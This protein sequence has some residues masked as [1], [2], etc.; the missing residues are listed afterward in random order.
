[1]R[2]FEPSLEGTIDS[3]GRRLQKRLVSS[4]RPFPSIAEKARTRDVEMFE[5]VIPDPV[6]VPT[7]DPD[8][9]LLL[10][11]DQWGSP[12]GVSVHWGGESDAARLRPPV[13]WLAPDE[14]A[15]V[16][17]IARNAL[18]SDPLA[19]TLS[20]LDVYSLI[21]RWLILATSGPFRTLSSWIV[22][23]AS[24][25][26][27]WHWIWFRLPADVESQLPDDEDLQLGGFVLRQLYRSELR[28]LFRRA[29]SPELPD[30]QQQEAIR[31]G[32]DWP[33]RGFD[34]ST[35]SFIPRSPEPNDGL[36][37][38]V[39]VLVRGSQR[40]SLDK[41]RQLYRELL[42]LLAALWAPLECLPLDISFRR[43]WSQPEGFFLTKRC[44]MPSAFGP[45]YVFADDLSYEPS[46]DEQPPTHTWGFCIP[47]DL[48]YRLVSLTLRRQVSLD[49]FI[50]RAAVETTEGLCSPAPERRLLHFVTA[51]EILFVATGERIAESIARRVSVLL[52]PQDAAAQRRLRRLM[53]DA[54]DLRSR[55]THEGQSVSAPSERRLVHGTQEVLSDALVALI[56]NRSRYRSKEMLLK[57]LDQRHEAARR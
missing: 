3:L 57:R 10:S 26:A 35:E 53:K 25:S 42:G 37:P 17:S 21:V 43:A 2:W 55:L 13:D 19:Q 45:Q 38:Y 41:G 14:F 6:S 40:R 27:E 5:I 29:G 12:S 7:G 15:D 51:A 23:H 33:P 39:S 31:L 50:I 11:R 47:D 46:V 16:H 20:E 52:G 34:P 54:Y 4:G 56:A 1:M 8:L 24:S 49:S 30:Q 28:E 18:K 48:D 32:Q 44:R 36:G 9:R 22:E